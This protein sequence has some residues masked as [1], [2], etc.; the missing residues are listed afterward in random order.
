MLTKARTSSSGTVWIAIRVCETCPENRTLDC[1]SVAN[2][3]AIVAPV[4]TPSNRTL[5]EH[6]D[7]SVAET[8]APLCDSVP[9]TEPVQGD[10]PEYFWA[11]T[12]SVPDHAPAS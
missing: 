5:R 9:L 8:F 6:S 10:C 4:M 12:V 1:V 3:P 7:V 11:C 2:V